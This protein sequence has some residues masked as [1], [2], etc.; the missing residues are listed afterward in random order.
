MGFSLLARGPML[1]V[2]N[3]LTQYACPFVGFSIIEVISSSITMAAGCTQS[4]SIRT[5]LNRFQH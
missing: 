3:L 4:Y 5:I 1:G 2:G